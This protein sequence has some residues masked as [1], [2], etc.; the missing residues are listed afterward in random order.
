MSEQDQLLAVLNRIANAVEKNTESQQAL[1]LAL[2]EVEFDDDQR[3]MDGSLV[4]E[5]LN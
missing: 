5:A 3:Y 1:I 2:A 4:D